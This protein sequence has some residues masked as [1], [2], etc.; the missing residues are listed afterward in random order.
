[1]RPLPLLAAALVAASAAAA[2][3]APA[4]AQ[5]V[6]TDAGTPHVALGPFTA[7]THG[8]DLTGTR[9][10]AYWDGGATV[11]EYVWGYESYAEGSYG[12]HT[13]GEL[14]LLWSD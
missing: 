12:V 13:H 7:T 6:L 4:A 14:A 8:P 10:T 5:T 2:P 3:A 9:V 1:M 11:R